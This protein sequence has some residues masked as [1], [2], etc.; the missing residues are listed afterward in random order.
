MD[1]SSQEVVASVG[2][3]TF[4]LD[5]MGGKWRVLILL[6]LIPGALRFNELRRFLPEVSQRIMTMNLRELEIDGLVE[7]VVHRE[8]PPKIEYSLTPRGSTLVPVIFSIRDWGSFHEAEIKSIRNCVGNS[9]K[10]EKRA[11][12]RFPWGGA[13]EGAPICRIPDDHMAAY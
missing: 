9:R 5:V 11:L 3:V 1:N 10:E 12:H 8:R 4:A 6:H 13:V 2:P 7:R